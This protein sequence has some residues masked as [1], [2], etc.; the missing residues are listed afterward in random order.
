MS[1]FQNTQI[2]TAVLA[3]SAALA[4]AETLKQLTQEALRNNPELRVV[5]AT[6]AAAKGGVTAA[7]TFANPELSV[8]PGV[9]RLQ[10]GGRN[11]DSFHA[12]FGL[13]QPFKFPGKRALEIAIAQR[14]VELTELA[15]EGFRFQIAARVRKAYYEFLVGQKIAEARAGQEGSARTVV[16]SARKRGEAAYGSDFETIKSQAELIAANKAFLQAQAA[17][18]N[19]RVTLNGLMGRAA[20]A[21]L[22]VAGNLDDVQPRASRAN[23]CSRC[24]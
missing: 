5:E 19:A 1:L 15:R 22:T 16:Q 21:P 3:V 12:E 4:R 7:R 24:S 23:C 6:I 2:I 20:N 13:S 11:A 18:N 8:A 14:N 17:V 9:R 10:E